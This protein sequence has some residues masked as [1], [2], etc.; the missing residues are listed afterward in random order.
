ML[1]VVVI[2]L[3]L[4]RFVCLAGIRY[5]APLCCD[6]NQKWIWGVGGE[7]AI[8]RSLI[9]PRCCRKRVAAAVITL[10]VASPP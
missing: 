2:S 6:T 5:I 10:P 3:C 8:N 9:T 7:V 1:F 4:S